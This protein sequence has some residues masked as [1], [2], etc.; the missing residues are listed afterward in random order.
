MTP[1]GTIGSWSGRAPWLAG[2]LLAAPLL[3]L[4]Y[5]P[6]GDLAM[7][8]ALV[9]ILRH[10]GEPGWAPPG[11][12]TVAAP[13]ANQLFHWLALGL[14]YALGRTDL[15]VKL[16]VAAI[17]AASPVT[18]A[19]MLAR[20]GRSRWAALLVAPIVC[21][22]MF[23]WGLV[24]N[25]LGFALLGLCL[26]LAEVVARR[27]T[28]RNLAAAA[29]ASC[30]LFLAH[31]STA[32]FF[33]L[34]LGFASAV[35]SPRPAALLARSAPILVTLV[36]VLVQWRVSRGL[37]GANMK[38]IGNDYGDDAITRI[39]MLPGGLFG[40]QDSTRHVWLG[41]VWALALVLGVLA[42]RGRTRRT[43][44]PLRVALWRYRH[45]LLALAF[46]VGFLGFPMSL[47]GNTLLSHRFLPVAC[48]FLVMACAPARER[49]A[50]PRY[51]LAAALVP[52]TTLGLLA[53]TYAQSD[54][55]HRDL[56]AVIA[57]LPDGVAIAQLD[58]TPQR[59]HRA[60]PVPGAASRAQA[61]HGG[62]M[63]FAFTDMPPNPVYMRP[64]VQWNEPVLRLAH[65]PFAFM[66]EHDA[67]RFAYLLTLNRAP[68]IRPIVRRAL[69]PEEELVASRGQWDLYRSTLPTVALD[70]PD[71][72]LPTPPPE[73]LAE[74]MNRA[75][76]PAATRDAP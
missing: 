70:A 33:A 54:R 44:F 25:M 71:A 46:L 53:S 41:A 35:R 37:E 51:A 3:A 36:L 57:H 5:P 24:A 31:E 58:L 72:P 73:T 43:T 38:A 55:G 45:A 12:Y 61:E 11:L 19:H 68:A 63:L 29:G 21:G 15:A 17:V 42:N 47:G 40:G 50:T 74:R 56:D 65:A 75:T 4:R 8:E 60:G 52:L 13:Q 49:L 20:L 2:L 1:T 27:P 9:A 18:T 30:L 14:S 26:P 6:M 67:R 28:G 66:P 59:A 10:R 39:A 7:H 32:I 76:A 69:A 23:T 64:E 22:W 34:V 62:R 48:L 16:L